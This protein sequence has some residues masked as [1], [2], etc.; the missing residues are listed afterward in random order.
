MCVQIQISPG[1]SVSDNPVLRVS[2]REL[3]LL[4][5][6]TPAKSRCSGWRSCLHEETPLLATSK[7]F[8]ALGEPFATRP[9]CKRWRRELGRGQ[10]SGAQ[11]ASCEKTARANR[12][13][14]G[15]V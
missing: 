5:R 4:W 3:A 10:A 6:S 12:G 7:A 1:V 11:E 14:R 2:V 13:L 8:G 9:C 15:R